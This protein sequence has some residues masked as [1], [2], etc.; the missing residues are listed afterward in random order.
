[1]FKMD[2]FYRHRATLV[3]GLFIVLLGFA[4][5]F[6][7]NRILASEEANCFETLHQSAEQLSRDIS[8]HIKNDQEMLETYAAIIAANNSPDSDEVRRLLSSFQQH[9]LISRLEI[10]FP[11]NKVLLSDNRLVDGNGILSF[12][13][14]AALGVH[15]SDREEDITD[16]ANLILRSYVPI[17]K[18]GK[19]IALL[20]GIVELETLAALWS[21]Q[22]YGGAAA[23]YVIEAATGNFIVDTWHSSLGN[24]YALGKRE[25]K[26]G[27]T[28]ENLAY[29]IQNGQRGHTVFV[30]HTAGENLYFYH[31]PLAINNWVLAISV[32]ESIA[33]RNFLLIEEMLF[34]FTV[35]EVV[36][37]AIYFL[38]VLRYVK[39]ETASKQKR[40]DMVNYV[41]AVEALL[42]TAHRQKEYIQLALGEIAD[43]ADSTYAFFQIYR[44][45][46]VNALYLYSR[47]KT[48]SPATRELFERLHLSIEDEL[49]EKAGVLSYSPA[50]YAIPNALGLSNLMA[51]PIK[52]A[53]G[54]SV[55]VLG[56]CDMSSKWETTELLESVSVCFSMLYNNMHSFSVIRQISETDVLTTLLNRN[57]FEKHLEEYSGKYKTS[58]ACIYADANGLHELNN[59]Y[60]HTAGD[61]LLQC[62][63]RTM[64]EAFGK[65]YTYRIGGDEFLS[66]VPDVPEE[67]I[68]EKIA[69]MRISLCEHGYSASIGYAWIPVDCNISMNA[70]V[71]M[72]EKEMYADKQ[73]YYRETGKPSR[74]SR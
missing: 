6:L 2:W 73:K 50:A 65:D 40:V 71:K 68:Q 26:A 61:K 10:L 37:F 30:S 3:T 67:Q 35:L 52:D 17:E 43:M 18:D 41:H 15:I 24:F 1:M 23:I 12:D 20:S 56:V 44:A 58:L 28:P 57:S 62:I 33:F 63:A 22:A 31:E 19:T 72:A 38:W 47:N 46:N 70:L 5:F 55:G 14:E 69:H 13:Q 39:Q 25:M 21:P 16:A 32:P 4:S 60:G 54:V 53:D 29:S 74:T 34:R 7:A 51:V 49:A 42:F 59:Q 9:G 11:D 36:F 45:P 66:F 8:S 64:L 48:V 27:Y